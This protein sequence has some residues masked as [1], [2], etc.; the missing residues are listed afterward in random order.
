[1]ASHCR[2]LLRSAWG[3]VFGVPLSE[4]QW[5]TASLPIRHGGFGIQ[6]PTRIHAAAAIAAFLS[7]ARGATGFGFSQRLY[8]LDP[9]VHWLLK[10][11]PGLASRLAPLWFADNLACI[12]SDASFDQWEQQRSWTEELADA[13][14]VRMDNEASSR[15]VS[16]RSLQSGPHSGSW[17]TA[18]PGWPDG[19][20][21]F[22]AADSRCYSF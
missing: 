17:I 2:T 5:S 13:A 10:E 4:V 16:L 9:A 18:L 19:A 20:S 6:D 3:T 1:M 14:L 22:S 8:D 21:V 11:A 12:T 15:L 7:A